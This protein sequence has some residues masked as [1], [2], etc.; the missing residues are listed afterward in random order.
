MHH[1]AVAAA[2]PAVPG[3]MGEK[4]APKPVHT[5]TSQSDGLPVASFLC[6]DGCSVCSFIISC[7]TAWR[8]VCL[9]VFILMQIY[10]KCIITDK[11]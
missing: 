2:A 5:S 11:T 10:K 8:F 4:P 6:D 3:A 7:D 1:I 9:D